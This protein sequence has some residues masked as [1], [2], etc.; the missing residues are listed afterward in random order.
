MIR[1]WAVGLGALCSLAVAGCMKSEPPA[2][3]ATPPAAEKVAPAEAMP[4][5]VTDERLL[6]AAT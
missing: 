4:A 3:G 1:N 6:N 5:N 2:T